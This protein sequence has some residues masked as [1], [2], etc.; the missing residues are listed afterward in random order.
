MT[1]F[2]YALLL[3]A[4]FALACVGMWWDVG[5]RCDRAQAELDLDELWDDTEDEQVAA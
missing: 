4:A 1:P 3:L 2:W 5:R